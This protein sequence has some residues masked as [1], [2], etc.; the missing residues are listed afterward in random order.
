MRLWLLTP[1]PTRWAYDILLHRIL[2]SLLLSWP[3]HIS[4][5]TKR[6]SEGYSGLRA[7]NLSW[8]RP[9]PSLPRDRANISQ[10][11]IRSRPQTRQTWPMSDQFFKVWVTS[12]RLR[13][14]RRSLPLV[15]RCSLGS[16]S[17]L[18]RRSSESWVSCSTF[19]HPPNK[20]ILFS[21]DMH[22]HLDLKCVVMRPL[23]KWKT[24]FVEPML[25]RFCFKIINM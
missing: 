7:S 10:Q 3:D 1:Q 23:E 15:A 19:N 20:S 9:P 4:C 5:P 2:T 22:C 6:T 13:G 17:A 12:H 14:P 18:T 8:L 16:S 25:E 24:S 11:I 21:V